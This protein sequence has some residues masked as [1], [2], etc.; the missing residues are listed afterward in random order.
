MP[1]PL[2]LRG[3]SPRYPLDRRLGRPQS[4]SGRRGE[5]KILGPTGTLVVQP[6]ASRYTDYAI[7]GSRNDLVLGIN[8]VSNTVC[9][10]HLMALR[11]PIFI[12]FFSI[13]PNYIKC[14]RHDI[15]PVKAWTLILECYIRKCRSQWPRG[16][17]HELSSLARTLRSRVRI[18][19]NAWMSVCVK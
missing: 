19:L 1:R 15:Y 9:E 16:L 5:E 8:A 6:V 3:K 11:R 4:R 12:Y 13:V 17:R 2:Y 14:S 18:P 7:P 10:G